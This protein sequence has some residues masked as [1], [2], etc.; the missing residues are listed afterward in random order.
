MP[1]NN[2]AKV[3]Q[4]LIQRNGQ[5]CTYKQVVQGTYDTVTHTVLGSTEVVQTLK[6]WPASTSKSDREN[7]AFVGRIVQS[8]LFAKLDLSVVPRQGDVIVTPAGTFTVE[9][10]QQHDYSG[11]VAVWRLLCFKS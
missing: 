1:S 3:A 2:L 11:G 9:R 6:G 10:V 5:S 8:L 7:P 4:R